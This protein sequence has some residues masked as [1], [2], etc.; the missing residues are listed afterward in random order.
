MS[1][2]EQE[3]QLDDIAESL[4]PTRARELKIFVD[5]H[6]KDSRLEYQWRNAWV[7]SPTLPRALAIGASFVAAAKFTACVL[8]ASRTVTRLACWCPDYHVGYRC[9]I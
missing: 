5:F 9:A 3:Q 4:P 2:S 1:V 8:S 6:F 7:S